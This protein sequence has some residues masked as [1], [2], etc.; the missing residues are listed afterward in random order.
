MKVVFRDAA[1]SEQ[2]AQ[3]GFSLNGVK[4]DLVPPVRP[5]SKV[6]IHDLPYH[7]PA[8]VVRP[9]LSGYGDVK[10]VDF[11]KAV[12]RFRSGDRVISMTLKRGIPRHI[13][14]A[15]YPAK[16]FYNGQPLFCEICRR[17]HFTSRCPLKGKCR[18]CREAG[19]VARNCPQKR[20]AVS[21]PA[22]QGGSSVASQ[23]T[24]QGG[25]SVT[26]QPTAQGGLQTVSLPG[27]AANSQST[28]RSGRVLN[29]QSAHRS[30]RVLLFLLW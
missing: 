21:Q 24:A 18:M 30:G 4:V 2:F 12:E 29:R 9:S 27:L 7:M 22:A 10:S 25:S 1:A 13:V 16:V 17:A 23:P 19:H 20:V 8:G 11:R 28:H 26:S 3:C 14:V 5:T 15:G 6:I